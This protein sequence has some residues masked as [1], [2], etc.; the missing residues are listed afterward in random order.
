MATFERA[1][2]IAAEAHEGM[3]DKA[4]TPY[5]LHPLSVMM[6]MHTIQE[7]IAAVLHDVVEDSDQWTLQRLKDE[8]FDQYIID[9]VDALTK[10]EEETYEEFIE[11]VSDNAIAVKVK[12][13]D[14][15]D[16]MDITRL[17][18]LTDKDK[19]RIEQYHKA[20]M[21]LQIKKRPS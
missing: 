15:E 18:N 3:V 4:G 6:R 8:G 11:R 16:N 19:Q 10:R 2:V 13:A 7:M 14:L 9:A 5:I 12:L 1:I 21:K 20:W 17:H